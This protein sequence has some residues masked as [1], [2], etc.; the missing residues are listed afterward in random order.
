MLRKENILSI[1]E[2]ADINS[3]G[4]LERSV[5]TEYNLAPN[6]TISVEIP[7]MNFTFTELARR[8]NAMEQDLNK[9]F[10]G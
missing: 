3:R 5:L 10:G 8:I 4:Q 7:K 1:R 6:V 9:V 2:T